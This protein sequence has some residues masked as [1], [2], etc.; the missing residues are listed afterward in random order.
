VTGP[1]TLQD[2][3]QVTSGNVVALTQSTAYAR[4]P[5][6]DRRRAFLRDVAA[7]VG[8]Q[9]AQSR[10]SLHDFV[11][12]ASHAASERRLLVWS[13]D[14][15]I[16]ALL[17]QT[18]LSGEIPET[19]APFAGL[20]VVNDG[21]NKLDYYLDRS[22]TY[23]SAGCGAL[24]DVTVTVQLTNNAPASGLP[25]AVTSRTDKH[26]Y[27]IEPGDNRLEVSYYATSNAQ[28]QSA[29]LDGTA[30]GVEIGAERQHPV[31]RLDIEL[32]RGTTRTVVLHLQEPASSAAPI[33]LRQPL[34]RPL[35]V[36]VRT[37]HC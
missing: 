33:V 34:V 31:Y 17:E 12:A 21:G 2:G 16:E 1:V 28:L 20:S 23:Q 25:G 6:R 8:T 27:P 22:L 4:F 3:T 9:I 5:D 26:S 24:R 36:D 35:T 13:G 11:D 37:P 7:T 30:V 18:S 14:P 10:A 19:S 15:H 29:S 32:P